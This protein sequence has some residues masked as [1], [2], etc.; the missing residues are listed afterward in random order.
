MR[1]ILASVLALL[2]LL[3]AAVP[4]F[5]DTVILKSGKKLDGIVIEF[6]KG[7]YRLKSGGKIVE[8]PEAN[9]AD[10][11]Y[12]A[13]QA[14]VSA[15]LTGEKLHEKPAG[16]PAKF[17]LRPAA[18]GA[19]IISPKYGADFDPTGLELFAGV[20]CGID[21]GG[22]LLGAKFLYGSVSGNISFYDPAAATTADTKIDSGSLLMLLDLGFKTKMPDNKTTILI[23][24]SPGAVL[25]FDSLDNYA[26]GY[27]DTG[28]SGTIPLGKVQATYFSFALM[29]GFGFEYEV[30][31]SFIPGAGFNLICFPKNKYSDLYAYGSSPG[32]S[33]MFEDAMISLGIAIDVTARFLF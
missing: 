9:V 13:D 3:F 27:K 30:S 32:Q 15:A 5:P 23:G 12:T 26:F 17:Y 4:V 29:G 24:V 20:S 10:V 1:V 14:Q 28:Y 22:L 16:P 19:I 21:T 6:Y 7:N 31:E 33:G 2:V 11:Q 25:N 8:I 18:G